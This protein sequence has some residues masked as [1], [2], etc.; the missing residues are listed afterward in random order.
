M[1]TTSTKST[2]LS[3]TGIDDLEENTNSI[4]AINEEIGVIENNLSAESKAREDEDVILDG[5]II[6]E[7]KAREDEDVILDGR[8]IAESKAREDEDVI[9]DGRIIAESKSRSDEDELLDSRIT[10]ETQQRTDEDDA[11]DG[12]ITTERQERIFADSAIDFRLDNIEAEIDAI[13]LLIT[14]GQHIIDI[15]DDITEL[16]ANTSNAYIRYTEED[17]NLIIGTIDLSGNETNAIKYNTDVG[18][19]TLLKPNSSIVLP[20]NADLPTRWQITTVNEGSGSKTN[21]NYIDSSG[22]PETIFTINSNNIITADNLITIKGNLNNILTELQTKVN[23]L[24]KLQ[25]DLQDDLNSSTGTDS[26]GN[27]ILG[28]IGTV[29]GVGNTLTIGVLAL[30]VATNTT[31]IGLLA[32]ATGLETLNDTVT[33]T[34]SLFNTFKDAYNNLFTAGQNGYTRITSSGVELSNLRMLASDIDNVA[35]LNFKQTIGGTIQHL[36]TINDVLLLD[37]SGVEIPQSLA[38]ACETTFGNEIIY[39]TLALDD[40]FTNKISNDSTIEAIQLS[41]DTKVTITDVT[42]AIMMLVD[43]APPLLNT[44]SELSNALNQNPDFGNNVLAL[45]STNTGGLVTATNLIGTRESESIARDNLK[46]SLTGGTLSGGLTVNGKTTIR[47][48]VGDCLAIQGT[49]HCFMEWFPNTTNT[50]RAYMGFSNANSQVLQIVNQFTSSVVQILP[51]LSTG[52]A[53]LTGALTGTTANFS[54]ALTAGSANINGNMELAGNGRNLKFSSTENIGRFN[55]EGGAQVY[56][57]NLENSIVRNADTEVRFTGGGALLIDTHKIT[58]GY[59]DLEEYNNE[60]TFYPNNHAMKFYVKNRDT[61]QTIPA[62]KVLDLQPVNSTF[63]S[64]FINLVGTTNVT[65]ALAVTGALTGQ[66]ITAINDA[67]ALNTNKL[68]ITSEQRDAILANT[69]KLGI[70]AEQATAISNIP[71]GLDTKLDK[72]GSVTIIGDLTIQNASQTPKLTLY[73]PNN[74]IFPTI[75]FIRQSSVFGVD[76]QTDYRLVNQL[77]VFKILSQANSGTLRTLF[78]IDPNN[79]ITISDGTPVTISGALTGTTANFSGAL[80]GQTI[81]VINATI[82]A[83]N[84]LRSNGDAFLNTALT[85]LIGTRNSESIA[86][87]ALKLDKTGGTLTGALTVSNPAEITYK[88][89]NLD[90]RFVSQTAYDANNTEVLEAYALLQGDTIAV[91]DG[92]IAR[93]NLKLNLSG[94]SLTGPLNGTTAT[95]SGGLTANSANITNNLSC[96]DIT[97]DSIFATTI[98]GIALQ[99]IFSN[100]F[101]ILSGTIQSSISRLRVTLT[102]IIFNVTNTFNLIPTGTITTT[103]YLVNSMPGYLLCDGALMNTNNNPEYTKLANLLAGNYGT[104]PGPGFF[105]LPDFRGMFLR[106]F[107]SQN[108]N[109]VV[110][111]SNTSGFENRQQDQ[112]LTPNTPT[113]TNRG[114]FNCRGGADRSVISRA[115]IP[116]LDAD[117]N[118]GIAVNVSFPRQGTENRPANYAV[119]YWIRF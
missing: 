85:N 57:D 22:L 68:G 37:V 7:S 82:L 59:S 76:P 64:T 100:S 107:G 46:L 16:K 106:G 88:G 84:V 36:T 63:N 20:D 13:D 4:V 55:T 91:Q 29:F 3:L 28:I 79:G 86:R 39:K 111:S 72:T 56:F 70:S 110:Y 114:Y 43:D 1:D 12:R 112:V 32:T 33:Q 53:T 69:D 95:F 10:A 62:V 117:S 18:A 2:F 67:V 9:L 50:R 11:L 116:Q 89:Q 109:G 30:Q 96:N 119:K 26:G 99:N 54:G 48:P 101:D 52:A 24:K 97:S 80:T 75:E 17:S 42:N 5:R 38:I 47:N 35:N 40:R 58:M 27:P 65:G 83:N 34:R 87:D 92:S 41:L 102:D 51:A 105:R 113:V 71:A 8:I 61:N 25:D 115:V 19:L 21:F 15:N 66:T 44:L 31:A 14:G 74:S 77:G 98:R 104:V 81:D 108:V 94:G 73:A 78:N 90:N 49:A 60:N 45:I 103:L 118:T 23:A 93:D 6:A